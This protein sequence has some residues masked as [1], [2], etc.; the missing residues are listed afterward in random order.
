[1]IGAE[2]C[3]KMNFGL[4]LTK[5]AIDVMNQTK[6][7]SKAIWK[8]LDKVGTFLNLERITVLEKTSN[9]QCF[10]ATYDWC[11][12]G[13][14]PIKNHVFTYTDEFKNIFFHEGTEKGNCLQEVFLRFNQYFNLDKPFHSLSLNIKQK[15]NGLVYFEGDGH[16][17]TV[18]DINIFLHIK[19]L[20]ETY[21][22]IERENRETER[23]LKQL[24]LYDPITGLVKYD[25]FLERAEEIYQSDKS[26]T[27]YVLMYAD[28]QNFKYFNEFFG[29]SAGDEVL[30]LFEKHFMTESIYHLIGCRVFS[31]Y[32]IAL[33][34]IDKNPSKRKLILFIESLNKAFTKRIQKQYADARIR[35][36]VGAIFIHDRTVGIKTY[37]DNANQARKVAKSTQEICVIFDEKMEAY[38]KQ[39]LLI[40][41]RAEEAL[42]ANEF[43]VVFQPK[44]NLK[45]KKMVGAEALV[46][47]KDKD[48]NE[49][50]P[51]DFIPIFEDNGFITKLDFYV[52]AKVCE[53]IKNRLDHKLKLVP[54][55]VNVSRIHLSQ[56]NFARKVTRLVSQ[57]QIPPKYLEF[58]LTE[59]VFL[60]HSDEARLTMKQLKEEGFIVSMDDFGSGYS[61][62]NLLTSVDFDI[63]KLD[64]EFLAEAKISEKDEVV[65]QSIIKMAKLMNMLTLCEGVENQE[66]ADVLLRLKCDLVQGY[67]FGKPMPMH[68]FNELLNKNEI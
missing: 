58:E 9:L 38:K 19:Y 23:K 25:I 22:F 57:Y 26:D 37:V 60:Q 15:R 14:K 64:K 3:Q 43:Y 35:I 36:A 16:E 62:L 53:Y 32:F 13:A 27:Q 2:D 10:T 41:N 12:M 39:K 52:Y 47:W 6:D 34:S 29:Y 4:E 21:F 63:L 24:M 51:K 67:H 50:Y 42:K 66:Q 45:T 49:H 8:V 18:E 44:I 31:D 59:S 40:A 68:L 48:G 11:S 54:I 5:Y 61:S 30:R 1:M 56:A 33:V 17:F 28:M 46:R 65:I 55:S 20:F 7:I